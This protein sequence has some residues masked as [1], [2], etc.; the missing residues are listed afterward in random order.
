M[1]KLV[2]AFAVAAASGASAL[3]D[4]AMIEKGENEFNKCG[5][6]HRIEGPDGLIGRF[7]GK[8]GPNLY[9]VAGRKAGSDETFSRSSGKT[10][11]GKGLVAAAEKGLVWD[12][13]SFGKYVHD[14]KDFLKEYLGESSVQV[15][16]AA[17]KSS[18]TD[19]VWAYL[20]SL[21]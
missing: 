5:T 19:A 13:D 7:K 10:K 18:D 14:P 12:K 17:Q 3:A 1:K 15:K 21:K 9:G 6:C 20:E 4:P 2:L 16:M 8:T 11:Y